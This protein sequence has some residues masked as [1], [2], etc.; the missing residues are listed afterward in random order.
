VKTYKEAADYL[1]KKVSRPLENNT[2][3]ERRDEST[4]AVKLH[5]TDIVKYH[6]D[7]SITVTSGGWHTLTTKDRINK[8]AGLRIWQANSVWYINQNLIFTDNGKIDA[9]GKFIGFEKYTENEAKSQR[10]L[11]KQIK[12]YCDAYIEQLRTGKLNP[13]S[14]GD[15]W[16]CSMIVERTGRPLGDHRADHILEHI[17]EKYYVPSLIMNVAKDRG[18][19]QYAQWMINAAFFYNTDHKAKEFIDSIREENW[20]WLVRRHLYIYI[21][22]QLGY[23]L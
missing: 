10:K 19:P 21:K 17:K 3:I 18:I 4:I 11:F 8:Y 14:G 12:E 5:D 22:S 23:G 16:D 20:N 1:G 13:P 2:R 9:K 6:A 15:C 7:G